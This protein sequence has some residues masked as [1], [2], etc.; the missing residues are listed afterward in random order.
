MIEQFEI[1]GKKLI[2]IIEELEEVE[3]MLGA[4]CPCWCCR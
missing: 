2:D 4:V 1:D 3:P